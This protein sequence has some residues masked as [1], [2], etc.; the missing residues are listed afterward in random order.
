MGLLD[1]EDHTLHRPAPKDS[2]SDERASSVYKGIFEMLEE[3]G[4]EE[5]PGPACGAGG[6]QTY[7]ITRLDHLNADAVR[8]CPDCSPTGRP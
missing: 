4:T 6:V 1:S 3:L 2:E 7:S 8:Y 5:P